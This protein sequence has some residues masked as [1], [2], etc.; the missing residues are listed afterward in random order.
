MTTFTIPNFDAATQQASSLPVKRTQTHIYFF[1]Y[2]GPE[3]EVCF[4]QWSPSPII[5][6]SKNF[7]T[8]EHYMMYHKA[9]LFGDSATAAR[10]LSAETPGEAKALGREAGFVNPSISLAPIPPTIKGS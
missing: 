10:I 4:Q 2:V 5:E 1:G 6:D 7:P 8:S 9:L 3:P